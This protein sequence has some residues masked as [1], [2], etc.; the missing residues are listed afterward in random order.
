[1]LFTEVDISELPKVGGM[2]LDS[3]LEFRFLDIVKER[4]IRAG[5]QQGPPC[6][7]EHSPVFRNL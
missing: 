5:N 7:F 1:V 4:V 6:E 3:L 2:H